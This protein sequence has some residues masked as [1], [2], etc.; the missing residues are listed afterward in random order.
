MCLLADDVDRSQSKAINFYCF[1]LGLQ[2]VVI[3]SLLYCN[4]M[5]INQPLWLGVLIGRHISRLVDLHF[6]Q[7]GFVRK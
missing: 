3:P 6:K 4:Q 7:M 5:Q 2:V 1:N